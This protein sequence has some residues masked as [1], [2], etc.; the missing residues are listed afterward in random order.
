MLLIMLHTRLTQPREMSDTEFYSI[1]LEEGQFAL[2][3]LQ[4][5]SA[6]LKGVWKVAGLQE[7]YALFEVESPS[8]LDRVLANVPM[9]KKGYGHMLE[10]R[11]QLLSPY[12]DWV[13]LLEDIVKQKRRPI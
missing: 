2:Q 11:Y 7:V 4:T 8:E 13:S 1:W 12:T 6:M 10:Q 3:A 5:P 9:I